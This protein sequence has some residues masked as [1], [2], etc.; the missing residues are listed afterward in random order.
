M[1]I[2]RSVLGNRVTVLMMTR[3]SFHSMHRRHLD[4]EHQVN[5]ITRSE[6]LY[7]DFAVDPDEQARGDS[8]KDET[9]SDVNQTLS[10][11]VSHPGEII[12]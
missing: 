7:G 12:H 10:F 8:S 6:Q 1:A 2:I 3:E 9:L 11:S 4:Q 5:S